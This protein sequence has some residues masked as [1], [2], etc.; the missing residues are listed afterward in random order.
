MKLKIYMHK[1]LYYLCFFVLQVFISCSNKSDLHFDE[2]NNVNLPDN[3]ESKAHTIDNIEE[4]FD[5]LDYQ[6]VINRYK[7]KFDNNITIVRFK[8]FVIFSDLEPSLTFKLIDKDLRNTITGM[9]NYYLTRFPDSVTAIFLFEEFDTYKDFSVK[10][11]NM[12]V[13]ELSPYGYY[14]ISK[15]IIAI[16]YIS[17]KGSLSHE[18]THALI[19]ADFPEMSSW[20]NEGLASLHENARYN[21]GNLQ[22]I[23]SWRILALR[24]AFKE[25][26]YTDLRSLMETDDEE[27]YSNRSSFYYAQARYLF[28]YIQ[29]MGLLSRYYKEYK[30][31]FNEDETGITQLERLT[32]KPLDE[33]DTELVEFIK[34]FD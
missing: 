20:F 10:T 21:D 17:W 32:G 18:T 5:G 1:R 29:E 8:Y 9:T 12:K 7:G 11:F 19:Q 25:N 15:N 34:N 26:S 27:L 2:A 23:F 30:N 16:R 31:T 24:R 6:S 13:S 4:I 22:A 14:K 3:A 28:M 33:I